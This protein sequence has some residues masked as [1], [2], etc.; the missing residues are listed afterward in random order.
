MFTNPLTEPPRTP[1][2]AVNG[3]AIIQPSYT[4]AAEVVKVQDGDSIIARVDHGGAITRVWKVR[5]IGIDAPEMRGVTLEAGRAAREYL[6]GLLF[7]DWHRSLGFEVRP[8]ARFGSALSAPLVMETWKD[9]RGYPDED[10]YGRLLAR[11]YRMTTA[12]QLDVNLSLVSAGHAVLRS[13]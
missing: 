3:H 6:A 7:E 12:G 8:R 4:F 13:Y 11:V 9:N 2:H 10:K 1:V 5:L